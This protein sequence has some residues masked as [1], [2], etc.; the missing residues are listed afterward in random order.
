MQRGGDTATVFGSLSLST[1]PLHW[2]C[3][4]KA[5]LSVCMKPSESL[6]PKP[7]SGSGLKNFELLRI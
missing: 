1:C 3:G 6:P 2:H 5:M 4:L 7:G